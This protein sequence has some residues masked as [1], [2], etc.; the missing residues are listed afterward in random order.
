[1][2]EIST[3][4]RKEIEGN[5]SSIMKWM[6]FLYKYPKAFEDIWHVNS[7]EIMKPVFYAN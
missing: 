3:K 4:K 5:Y 7:N 2:E 6:N 1:L